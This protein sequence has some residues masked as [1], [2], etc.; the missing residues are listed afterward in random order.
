[1]KAQIDI[2]HKPSRLD[3]YGDY[4]VFGFGLFLY[5]LAVSSLITAHKNLSIVFFSA[6]IIYSA[7]HIYNFIARS[8]NKVL[9]RLSNNIMRQIIA[10]GIPASLVVL[11]WY[12][13]N[14]I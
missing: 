8:K 1:M 11:T 2:N 14:A 7:E 13:T 10:L 6:L 3:K 5:L 4:L 9:N 12:V